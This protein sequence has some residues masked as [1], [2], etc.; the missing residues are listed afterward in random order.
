MQRGGWWWWGKINL[1]MV[2]PTDGTEESARP[3]G[4]QKETLMCSHVIVHRLHERRGK[5]NS[6]FSAVS[7][8]INETKN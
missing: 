3:K 7:Q 8:D 6:R 4:F 5:T 1:T 2:G